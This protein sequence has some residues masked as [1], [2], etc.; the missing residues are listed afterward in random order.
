MIT[1][2]KFHHKNKIIRSLALEFDALLK[3]NAIS[4]EQAASI[5]TDLETKIIQAVSAIRF[6]ENLNEFFK[7]HQEFAKTGKEIE[8]MINELLQKI[9][10]E[11]TESVVDDDPEA[12]EV[13]SQKTTDINEKNLDEFAN[14]LPETAYPNFI[15]KLINA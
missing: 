13:L 5:K 7:N 11:C 4:K 9:G 8:N 15:Q 12:W 1:K 10:E 14:D 6:C 3:K 2:I